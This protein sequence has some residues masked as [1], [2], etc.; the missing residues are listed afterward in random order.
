MGKDIHRCLLLLRA[1]DGATRDQM[2]AALERATQSTNRD[3]KPVSAHAAMEVEN[4]PLGK[5]FSVAPFGAALDLRTTHGEQA[6]LAAIERLDK[7]MTDTFDPALSTAVAGIEHTIDAGD[8]D[9]GLFFC[10]RPKPGMTVPEFHDYWLN[11]HA[12]NYAHRSGLGYRQLHATDELTAAA[13]AKFGVTDLGYR[14]IADAVL[15]SV[16]GMTREPTRGDRVNFVDE[17][18]EVGMVVARL[19]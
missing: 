9:L 7:E 13:S 17:V 6:L 15:E 14:G 8:G 16:P 1:R 4:D 12:P 3:A 5:G 18:G 2:R 11:V 10:M 19:P